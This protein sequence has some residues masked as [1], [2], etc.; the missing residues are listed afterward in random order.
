M[1]EY[2]LADS[3]A[4]IQQLISI[5]VLCPESRFE[6]LTEVLSSKPSASPNFRFYIDWGE[7]ESSLMS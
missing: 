5:A 3:G 6:Q 7:V 4:L 2:T 1:N